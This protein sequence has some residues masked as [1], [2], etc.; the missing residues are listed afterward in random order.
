MICLFVGVLIIIGI[1]IFGN[2]V[3]DITL[4]GAGGGALDFD[5]DHLSWA[6]YIGI[7]AGILLFKAAIFMVV[8]IMSTANQ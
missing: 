5:A 6:W 2:N 1:S 8:G 4:P 3:T 7:V